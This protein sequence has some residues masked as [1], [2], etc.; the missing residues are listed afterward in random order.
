MGKISK[1]E[2]RHRICY[3]Y[4][5]YG[6]FY[7][8]IMWYHRKR[9]ESHLRPCMSWSS[10]TKVQTALFFL[11]RSCGM[12]STPWRTPCAIAAM[13]PKNRRPTGVGGTALSIWT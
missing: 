6:D 7:D 13:G 10:M 9:F 4:A 11:K 8:L 12:S 5:E 3:E 1:S 2:P